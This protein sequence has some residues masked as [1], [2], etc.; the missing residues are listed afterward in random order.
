MINYSFKETNRELYKSP[1]GLP[2]SLFLENFK[3]VFLGSDYFIYFRNSLFITLTSILCI[4]IFSSLA[5]Y[6]LAKYRF[7]L[8]R[9]VYLFFVIGL[10][11]P[12]RLGTINLLQIMVKIN[13]YNN[14]LALIIIYTAIGLPLAVFILT[15][16]IRMIPEELSNSARIDGC[17]EPGIFYKIIVP[18]IKPAIVTISIFNSLHIWNDFWFPLIFIKSNNLRPIPLAVAVMLS[19]YA[20]NYPLVFTVLSIASLPM[21]IFYLILSRQY[22]QGITGGALKY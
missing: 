17:S 9:I 14:L 22:V 1:Y 11:I 8:D 6:V 18:M 12:I 20:I 7:R 15:D 10:F 21:I 2:K 16:F 5:A 4:V 13:L 19:E 3:E